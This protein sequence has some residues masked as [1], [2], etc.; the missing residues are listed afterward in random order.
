MAPSLYNILK[1]ERSTH[2]AIESLENQCKIV[3]DYQATALRH[4]GLYRLVF[5]FFMS[6]LDFKILFMYIKLIYTHPGT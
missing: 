2:C 1:T 3:V 6:C 4:S 5:S